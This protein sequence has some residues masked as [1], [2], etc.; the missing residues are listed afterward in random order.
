MD[1]DQLIVVKLDSNPPTREQLSTVLGSIGQMINFVFAQNEARSLTEIDPRRDILV[2]AQ[3]GDFG[4][5]DF[6]RGP[7]AIATGVAAARRVSDQLAR[8]LHDT[9]DGGAIPRSGS[10]ASI[11]SSSASM[12]P[13]SCPVGRGAADPHRV[14]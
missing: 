10:P 8:L 6:A 14:L 1:V 5:G 11:G 13:M 4:P 9:R 7:E 2:T 12:S 3:L